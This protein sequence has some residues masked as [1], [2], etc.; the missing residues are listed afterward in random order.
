MACA[1]SLIIDDNFRCSICLEAF[2]KPVSTPC[3]HNFCQACITGYWNQKDIFP[4]PLC[5]EQFCIKPELKV[6]TF[7]AEITEKHKKE[8]EEKCSKPPKEAE[9]GDVLCD[10]CELPAFKSCLVCLTSFCDTHL[11]RHRTVP[12]LKTHDLIDPAENLESRLCTKHH[13]QLELFCRKEQVI[14]CKSCE[15]HENHELVSLAEEATLRKTQLKKDKE[16]MDLLIAARQQKIDEFEGSAEASRKNAALALSR[17]ENVMSVVVDYV[18]K[19]HAEL[20]EVIQVQ[21][22]K[23]EMKKEGL[24]KEVE[25]EIMQIM[26]T[27]SQLDQVSLNNDDLVFLEN[28]LPLI[29][30]PPQ[31]KDWSDVTLNVNPFV[32]TEAL[33]ELMNTVIREIRMVCDPDFKGLKWQAVDVTLDPDTANPFL[34]VSEDGKQ[35]KHGD[36]ER[37][38]PNN[39]L[40]FSHVPNILAKEGFASGQFYYEVHVKNK[41]N[42]DLGVANRSINRVG[43]LRLS[44]RTGYWTI[45]LRD[46]QVYTANDNVPIDLSI[47]EMPEKVGVFVK[48]DE[49]LVAF[50]NVDTRACIFSYTGCK[51]TEELFPFFSPGKND[52]GKNSAPLIITPVKASH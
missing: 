25:G 22:K 36:V 43:D 38:V 7:I 18:K 46:G 30:T 6:N 39:P 26:Q 48:Y 35:V 19:S 16:E 50:F 34:L 28:F 1:S 12:A 8:S 47:R 14:V 11:E 13:R 51:F 20:A 41:T 4:C 17:R 32:V 24:I 33:T 5:Q 15:E 3:G 37:K 52:N 9:N 45:C 44:P 31:V 10:I 42:W 21:Q 40:R 27:K 29:I 49:G 2:K 23:I